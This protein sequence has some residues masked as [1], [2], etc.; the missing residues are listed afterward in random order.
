MRVDWASETVTKDAASSLGGMLACGWLAYNVVYRSS[1]ATATTVNDRA[2]YLRQ[3]L[4]EQDASLLL[5][6]FSFVLVCCS[7]SIDRRLRI[8]EEEDQARSAN[9]HA[10]RPLLSRQKRSVCEFVFERYYEPHTSTVFPSTAHK[11]EARQPANQQTTEGETH[12]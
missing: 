1:S 4:K 3:R 9:A 7:R 2:I 6:F 11:N 10:R 5:L 8:A 12:P